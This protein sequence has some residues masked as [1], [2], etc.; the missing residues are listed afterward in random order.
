MDK[1]YL[2]EEA[3]KRG[4]LTQGERLLKLEILLEGHLVHHDKLTKCLLYPIAV[5]VGVSILLGIVS[6]VFKSGLIK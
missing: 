5:G 6:L 3:K 2:K 4:N 1:N